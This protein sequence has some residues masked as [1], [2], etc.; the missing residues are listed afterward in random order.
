MK[1]TRIIIAHRLS[2]IRNAGKIYVL[3]RGNIVQSG[4]FEELLNQK[5]LFADLMTRQLA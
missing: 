4:N 3:D 2:T 1:L 5:G